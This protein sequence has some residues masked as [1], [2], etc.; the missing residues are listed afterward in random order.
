MKKYLNITLILFVICLT[1]KTHQ[2]HALGAEIVQD[3]GVLSAIHKLDTTNALN[4]GKA[5]A[6]LI[7]ILDSLNNL[8][9]QVELSKRMA[10]DLRNGDISPDMIN[11]AVSLATKCGYKPPKIALKDFPDLDLGKYICRTGGLPMREIEAKF[12]FKDGMSL[13]QKRKVLEN[14]N[15]L[16]EDSYTYSLALGLSSRVVDVH[17]DVQKVTKQMSNPSL[18]NQIYVNNQV[19]LMMVNQLVEIRR[20]LGAILENSTLDKA[21]SYKHMKSK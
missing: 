4:A 20:L 7:K 10:D 6:E 15:K 12:S 1:F 21:D 5:T 16:Q 18:S 13:E 8:K 3:P 19:G 9:N 2:A 11:F 14:L 17:D